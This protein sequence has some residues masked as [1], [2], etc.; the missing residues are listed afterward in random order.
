MHGRTGLENDEG[1]QVV[2]ALLSAK[3]DINKLD[4]FDLSPL[5]HASMRGNIHVVE[6]L[7]LQANIEIDIKDIQKSTPLHIAATYGNTEVVKILLKAGANC[8]MLD[9]QNQNPL[10]RAAKEGN[11]EIVELIIDHLDEAGLKNV[12]KQRD[13]EKNSPL[14][15]AVQAG[16]NKAVRL[17]MEK[18]G[19][20]KYVDQPNDMGECPL[21]SATRSGDKS[22]VEILVKYKARINRVNTEKES[23][24]FLAA[25]NART[26][27]DDEDESIELVKFLIEK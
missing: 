15:L 10:H 3:A 17:F 8:E 12:M 20:A 22:T 11:N 9:Y 24:L 5:H 2:E 25:E 7:T 27:D 16:N 14:L 18:G 21:H 26:E 1:V 19:S 23:P 6:Y 4:K 13:N